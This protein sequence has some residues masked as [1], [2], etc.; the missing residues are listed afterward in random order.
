[1]KIVFNHSE[2]LLSILEV[3]EE[4]GLPDS[5]LPSGHYSDWTAIDDH[6]AE[7]VA[8]RYLKSKGL[9]LY[10]V[11]DRDLCSNNKEYRL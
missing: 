11:Y 2:G 5:E 8:V 9:E 7:L 10:R 4:Y 6:V 3:A 1:M